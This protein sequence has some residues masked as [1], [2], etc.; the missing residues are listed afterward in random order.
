MYTFLDIGYC[1]HNRLQYSINK[2]FPCTGKPKN[3]FNLLWWSETKSATS[4]RYACICWYDTWRIKNNDFYDIP[5]LSIDWYITLWVK[6]CILQPESLGFT[7]PMLAW[8]YQWNKQYHLLNG[9]TDTL[10]SNEFRNMNYLGESQAHNK[11]YINIK[12]FY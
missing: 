7:L 12:Y 2:I 10:R 9:T 5:L 1:T 4:L 6:T 11:P 3:S 8:V